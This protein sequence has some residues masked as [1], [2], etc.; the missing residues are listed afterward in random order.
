MAII[1]IVAV[2][3][4]GAIG[5]GGTLPWHYP[6]DLRFFKE[7]T[8]G[9]A[10]VMGYRTWASLKRALP[11]RLNIVLTRRTDTEPRESVLWLRDKQSALSLYEYLKCDL[12]VLG[13]AQIFELFRAQ[14]D[15]W[16]VTRVPLTVADADTFLPPNLLE[17]FRPHDTRDLGD[18]L[19]VTFYE[20][21]R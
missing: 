11:N 12:Y 14:I 8:T 1:G 10:C 15:R 3:R 19:K 7:Q 13:G 9:N 16:L 20:R 2:D 4:A 5:K 21:A 18:D 17:G 6:A